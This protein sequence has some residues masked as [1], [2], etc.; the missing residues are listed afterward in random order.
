LSVIDSAINFNGRSIFSGEV[1]VE[2][3]KYRRLT[4]LRV[5]LGAMVVY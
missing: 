3:E 1:G 5:A 2:V 4:L